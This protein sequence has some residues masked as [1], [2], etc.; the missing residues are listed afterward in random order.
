MVGQLFGWSTL[1]S[2]FAGAIIAISSTTIIVKA[3]DEQG[4]RGGFTN[5]VFGILIVEDLIGILLI[6]I[7]TALSVGE[8]P[9]AADIARTA[10]RLAAFLAALL[11]VGL[12]IVPRLMRVIVKLDRPET[13]I[14]SSIGLAF[15]FSL[16]A[17]EC[18]YS[19]ALGAF[20]AGSLVAESGV[21]KTVEHLVQPIRDMFRGDLFC[22]RRDAHRAG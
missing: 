10:G 9:A 12:L 2:V 6:T 19:V 4:I 3:F 11:I 13:T 15:G 21:E 14:V 20:I 22:I 8:T 16:L 18:G 1:E 17:A 7:L 5:V